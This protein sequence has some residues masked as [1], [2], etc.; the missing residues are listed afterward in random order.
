MKPK[1]FKE[2]ISPDL[3]YRTFKMPTK[4]EE[5]SGPSKYAEKIW[6]DGKRYRIMYKT[7]YYKGASYLV[8]EEVPID[9]DEES[10]IHTSDDEFVKDDEKV[11]ESFKR[12]DKPLNDEKVA[13]LVN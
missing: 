13:H 4:E 10:S 11:R 5:I 12:E 3:R 7:I 1:V 9:S 8:D 2:S 6:R